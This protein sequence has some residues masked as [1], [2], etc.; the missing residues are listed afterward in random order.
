MITNHRHASRPF[1]RTTYTRPLSQWRCKGAHKDAPILSPPTKMDHFGFAHGFHNK[2]TV[3]EILG[4]GTFGCVHVATHKETGERFAVKVAVKRR[5]GNY[6][7]HD[8]VK[9]IQHEVDMYNHLGKSL[10]VV[11]MY[12]VF[13]DDKHVYLVMDLCSG[14]ELW[15]RI[16]RGQFNEQNAAR[17]IS[18]ILRTIA[19][20]HTRGVVVR[21][22]KPENFLFQD[23]SPSSPLKMID[24]GIAE[25][26]A[27]HQQLHDRAGTALY[28][29]P[30]LLRGNYSFK[31]DVW[32]AGVIAYEL[33]ADRMP[34]E[35]DD[36]EMLVSSLR[37]TRRNLSNKDIFHAILYRPLDFERPPWPSISD[38]AKDLVQRLL[39]RNPDERPT[40]LEALHHSWLESAAGHASGAGRSEG[41]SS[42]SSSSSDE[43]EGQADRHTSDSSASSISYDDS[44]VQRLQQY[45][46]YNRLKQVALSKLASFMAAYDNPRLAELKEAFSSKDDAGNLT[47]KVPYQKVERVLKS[48]E[49]DLSDIEVRQLLSSFHVD[50][51]GDIDINECV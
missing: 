12:D 24:F 7:Q 14:G 27:P 22:V 42:R 48:G 13:E 47:G 32:S 17:I 23:E 11:H 1:S 16:K 40:A 3:N 46:T 30:E 38:S 9:R 20:C 10:N 15:G 25:Y 19:Q 51:E 2:Y 31:A 26:C 37:T 4:C 29:A 43:E 28:C 36:G 21:D 35:D 6:L 39:T 18:E 34:F 33:I 50:S 8:F 49:F 41:Q 5:M 45:G 44:L